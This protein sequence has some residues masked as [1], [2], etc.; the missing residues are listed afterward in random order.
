MS[1]KSLIID[2]CRQLFPLNR[3]APLL[4]CSLFHIITLYQNVMLTDAHVRQLL[5]LPH[6]LIS[7]AYVF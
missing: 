3:Q 7:K 1:S 2:V 6:V 5:D 4:E